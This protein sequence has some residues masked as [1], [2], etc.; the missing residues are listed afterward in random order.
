MIF[1]NLLFTLLIGSTSIQANFNEK[2][3][4]IEMTTAS[5]SSKCTL[6]DGKISIKFPGDYEVSTNENEDVTTKKAMHKTE[7]G[8]V[9]YL[10][11]SLHKNSLDDVETLCETSL[12]SFAERIDGELESSSIIKYKKHKGKGAIIDYMEGQI[13][14]KVLIMGQNQI[15]I[16]VAS[17]SKDVSEEAAKFYKSFKYKG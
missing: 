6:N 15:Q 9:Y 3:L 12:N 11:W 13:N 2:P 10:S 1:T 4:N 17:G 14:Y 16:V 7:D 5:S 8:I